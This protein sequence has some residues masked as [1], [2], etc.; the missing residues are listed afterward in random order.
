MQILTYDR[1]KSLGGGVMYPIVKYP[2]FIESNLL[3]F[4]HIFNKCQKRHFAEYLTGLLVSKKKNISSM[5]SQFIN[6][7]NQSSKNHFLTDANWD[8]KQLTNERIAIVKEQCGKQHIK[9]GFLVID[10]SIT[11]R[12]GKHIESIDWFWDHSKNAYTLGHQ[13]VTSQYVTPKF[14]IPLHF[15]QYHK[16]DEVGK[17]QFKSKLD[18]TIELIQE[19]LDCGINFSC[20]LGDSWYFCQRIINYLEQIGKHWLFA[21]K[22]NRKVI[23]NNRLMQ[24]KD[25][26]KELKK[27]NF[28]LITVQQPSG[29][30]L[31]VYAYSK[32][33]RMH[34]VGRVKIVISFLDKPF[35]GNPFFLATNRKEW[36]L[37]TILSNYAK[38]W[39]IETFYRDAKQNLGLESCEMRRLKGIRR[40]WNLVFL[41]YTLLQFEAG[42][43]S[44]TKWIKS[45]VVTIGGKCR[46]ASCEVV[47]SFLFWAYEYF[48]KNEDPEYLF[49][50]IV[51]ND[52]QL[53][54]VF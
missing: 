51:K 32:T 22:S 49:K 39:P 20:V 45:N 50:E 9:D 8:N 21:S 48:E 44:L 2:S 36:T 47:R 27:E 1:I 5:N 53:K 15:R 46:I 11:H 33:V 35:S 52:H 40:H 13:L 26:V 12:T 23:F 6:H 4:E 31:T 25:V 34:N 19:A 42:S 7:T 43:S 37:D 28:K 18:L 14:H 38:R 54:I 24:L 30:T 29:K 17:E 41:A 3:R 16:E 10:D